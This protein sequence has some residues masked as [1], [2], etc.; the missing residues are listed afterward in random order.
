MIDLID[1][2]LAVANPEG[3]TAARLRRY[4]SQIENNVMLGTGVRA[5]LQS[6]VAKLDNVECGHL[7]R[8]GKCRARHGAACQYL[9]AFRRCPTYTRPVDRRRGKEVL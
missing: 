9:V 2:L 5:W 7:L 1:S 6:L 4:R 8:D 3:E